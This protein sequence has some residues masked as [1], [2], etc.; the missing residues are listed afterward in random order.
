LPLH[1]FGLDRVFTAGDEEFRYESLAGSVRMMDVLIQAGRDAKE[2][3]EKKKNKAVMLEHSFLFVVR[4]FT[5]HDMTEMNP[6]TVHFYYL[7]VLS[8]PL[9]SHSPAHRSSF[10]ICWLFVCFFPPFS[11]LCYGVG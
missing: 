1:S 6:N 7:Q 4:T 3:D 2:L 5:T 11:L 9:S 10:F 8:H